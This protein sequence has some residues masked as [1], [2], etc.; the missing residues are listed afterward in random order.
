M[1]ITSHIPFPF[2]KHEE[3]GTEL[4]KEEVNHPK[5]YGKDDDPY[6]V[7]KVIE[8]WNLNFPLGNTIKYIARADKKGRK[9]VDLKKALWYLQREISNIE[10]ASK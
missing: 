4:V 5:H 1:P 10:K 6:E 7:I 9:L 8:A 3:Q 2:C